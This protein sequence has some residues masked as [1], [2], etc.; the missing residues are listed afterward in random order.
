MEIAGIR[1][2]DPRPIPQTMRIPCV[3][4]RETGAIQHTRERGAENL[5]RH[6]CTRI[7][8]TMVQRHLGMARRES[9]GDYHTGGRRRECSAGHS[10]TPASAHGGTRAGPACHRA[11]DRRRLAFLRGNRKSREGIQHIIR[12]VCQHLFF[13]MSAGISCLVPPRQWRAAPHKSEAQRDAAV[14]A[15]RRKKRKAD[16]YI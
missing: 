1:H 9:R 14:Y 3:W 7:P 4:K 10:P 15:E 11:G 8:R 16:E 2:R 13:L 5:I 12:G 6:R